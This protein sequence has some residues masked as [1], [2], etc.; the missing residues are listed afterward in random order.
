MKKAITENGDNLPTAFFVGSDAMA[1]GCLRAL[2]EEKIQVPERVSIIGVND[3]SVSKYVI[4]SLSTV[5]VYT[6]LMGETAV[7]MLMERVD[8][9]RVVSK[10]VMISTKLKLRHSSN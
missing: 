4:P 3:I 6:E 1:I 2:H 9:K 8:S 5:K 7:E 10:K